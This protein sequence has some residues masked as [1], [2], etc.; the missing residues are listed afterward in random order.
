VKLSQPTPIGKSTLEHFPD[1]VRCGED[2][3]VAF[4]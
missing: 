3:G 2:R 1:A 4:P